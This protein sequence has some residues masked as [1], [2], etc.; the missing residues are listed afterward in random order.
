MTAPPPLP[1]DPPLPPPVEAEATSYGARLTLRNRAALEAGIHPATRRLLR[2]EGGTCGTCAHHVEV[3]RSRRYH[4]CD[5]HRYGLSASVASDVRVRWPACELWA[6]AADP[7]TG[8]ESS[9]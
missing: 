4:K 3:V 9:G 2:P 1:F 5:A 7:P 6:P 8:V